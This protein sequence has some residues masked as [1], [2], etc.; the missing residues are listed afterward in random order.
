M[1]DEM[2]QRL[3]ACFVG[4]KCCLARW[5]WLGMR[6]VDSRGGRGQPGP[7][8]GLGPRCILM[9]PANAGLTIICVSAFSLPAELW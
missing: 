4:V 9:S 8:C 1:V 3:A 6:V 2:F 5:G 7:A